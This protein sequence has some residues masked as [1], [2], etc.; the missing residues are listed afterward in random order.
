M[1]RDPRPMGKPPKLPGHCC[2]GNG[3]LSS[4]KNTRIS[5]VIR[6]IHRLTTPF[7]HGPEISC[8]VAILDDDLFEVSDTVSGLIVGLKD[9]H[10]R[11]L[12]RIAVH[13]LE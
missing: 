8:V 2:M 5:S 11:F 3:S 7:P 12:T 1:L 9:L 10:S 13:D 6:E 4:F